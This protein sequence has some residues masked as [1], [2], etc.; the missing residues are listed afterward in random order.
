MIRVALSMLG[1]AVWL[2][3]GLGARAYWGGKAYL[4]K[5]LGSEALADEAM[6][7]ALA[8]AD[9]LVLGMDPWTLLLAFAVAVS[10]ALVLGVLWPADWVLRRLGVARAGRALAGAGL[11]AVATAVALSSVHP[12]LSLPSVPEGPRTALN[13]ACEAAGYGWVNA[14]A[15]VGAVVT[16]GVVAWLAGSKGVEP[17]AAANDPAGPT[18]LLDEPDDPRAG[19]SAAQQA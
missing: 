15:Y 13:Y 14:I 4:A 19:P 12:L 10:A 5:L 8:E 16:G 11:A 7:R 6:R 1:L 9:A 3:A 2:A 17:Q 18:D